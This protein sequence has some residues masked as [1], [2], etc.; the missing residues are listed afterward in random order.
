LAALWAYS[1]AAGVPMRWLE[2]LSL[3]LLV[4][5]MGLLY[6]AP[7]ILVV[8]L[9]RHR[10]GWLLSRSLIATGFSISTGYWLWRVEWNDIWRHG[11]PSAHYAMVVYGPW[12]TGSAALGWLAGAIAVPR[13][14]RT[15]GPPRTC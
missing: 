2:T 6:N 10:L 8:Y 7:L 13:T 14:R 1:S 12:L 11:G 5:T 9:A 15:G 3:F 4:S